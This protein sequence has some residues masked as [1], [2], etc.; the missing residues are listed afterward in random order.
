MINNLKVTTEI[1]LDKETLINIAITVIRSLAI[2]ED[3]SF[4]LTPLD[5]HVYDGDDQ[6][7]REMNDNDITIHKTLKLLDNARSE[8]EINQLKETIKKLKEQLNCCEQLVDI[9]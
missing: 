1:N 5:K 4:Y 9:K 7:I 6:I 3:Q 2:E 8:S